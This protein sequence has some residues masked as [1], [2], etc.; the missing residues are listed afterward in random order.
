MFDVVKTVLGVAAIQTI[1]YSRQLTF[2]FHQWPLH[3]TPLPKV[4]VH[5]VR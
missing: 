4:S 1:E 5:R 3:E 2:G